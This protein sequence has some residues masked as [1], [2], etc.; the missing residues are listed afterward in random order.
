MAE[1]L[2]YGDAAGMRPRT[3]THGTLTT[4]AHRSGTTVIRVGRWLMPIVCVLGCSMALVFATE[5]AFLADKPIVMSAEAQDSSNESFSTVA[6]AANSDDW[7]RCTKTIDQADIDVY[8][9]A[10][11]ANLQQLRANADALCQGPLQV[12]HDDHQ[13]TPTGR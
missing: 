8:L 6:P 13:C 1:C 4:P 7:H 5:Q 3:R 10:I 2:Q 11:S 12:A 9:L